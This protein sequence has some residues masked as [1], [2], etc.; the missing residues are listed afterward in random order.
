MGKKAGEMIQTSGMAR[1]EAELFLAEQSP[2]ECNI[3][4]IRALQFRG[5]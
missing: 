1:S 5:I 2:A 3:I 4:S